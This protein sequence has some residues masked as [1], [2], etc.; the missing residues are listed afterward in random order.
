MMVAYS[1]HTSS[2]NNLNCIAVVVG[3]VTIKPSWDFLVRSQ[4]VR[5]RLVFA[6]LPIFSSGTCL[7]KRR[8]VVCPRLCQRP[9]MGA[10]MGDGKQAVA[11]WCECART[12]YG[13]CLAAH[14]SKRPSP[15]RVWGQT[16]AVKVPETACFLYPAGR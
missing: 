3:V 10:E 2:P 6:I 9:D 11:R 8:L 4:S 15:T 5:H 16:Y 14:P 13:M 1:L 7:V 12:M